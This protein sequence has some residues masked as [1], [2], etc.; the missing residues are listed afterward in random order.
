MKV[1][2]PSRGLFRK[3]ILFSN[4]LNIVEILDLHENRPEIMK[5]YP[6]LQ[7]FP[8]KFMISSTK[9]KIKEEE[10]W[11]SGDDDFKFEETFFDLIE[12]QIAVQVQEHIQLNTVV[13]QIDYSG[14]TIQ[15][16]DT[17]NNIFKFLEP[18]KEWLFIRIRPKNYAPKLSR[19]FPSQTQS[20]A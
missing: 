7:K 6:H 14:S 20:W 12:K 9:W 16:T 2:Q 5:F 17:N 4:F 11:S 13:K 19:C 8:G 3:N 10:N 18:K 1:C 15:V